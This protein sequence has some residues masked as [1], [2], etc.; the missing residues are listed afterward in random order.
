[1][2]I[3]EDG[4]YLLLIP[5]IL[6]IIYPDWEVEEYNK[7]KT[8]ENTKNENIYSLNNFVSHAYFGSHFNTELTFI[9]A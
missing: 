1:M 6:A 4:M 2:T 8:A 5:L 3:A 7:V 9:I